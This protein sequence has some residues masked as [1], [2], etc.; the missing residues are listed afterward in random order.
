MDIAWT[1]TTTS[2]HRQEYEA[3][4]QDEDI[5]VPL[6]PYGAVTPGFSFSV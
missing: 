2:P 4:R 6:K 3:E 5:I 1:G